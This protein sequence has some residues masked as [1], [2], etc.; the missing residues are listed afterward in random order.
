MAVSRVEPHSQAAAV[1]PPGERRIGVRAV[2]LLGPI[3]VCDDEWNGIPRAREF[4][5]PREHDPAAAVERR[6]RSA[7]IRRRRYRYRG[8]LAAKGRDTGVAPIGGLLTPRVAAILLRIPPPHSPTDGRQ[9]EAAAIPCRNAINFRVVGERLLN[10]LQIVIGSIWRRCGGM[11]DGGIRLPRP[12][13]GYVVR[14]AE[15][16]VSPRWGQ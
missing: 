14:M 5:R 3:L 12:E 8:R 1:T 13:T 15:R 16:E 6:L 9:Q 7:A 2:Q 10:L 11:H 4:L